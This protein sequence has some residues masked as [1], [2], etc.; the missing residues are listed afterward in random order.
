MFGTLLAILYHVCQD[1]LNRKVFDKMNNDLPPLI[2]SILSYEKLPPKTL[3]Q[4]RA[5]HKEAKAQRKKKI[6]KQRIMILLLSLS[7]AIT[8]ITW[9]MGII[10]A[11][12]LATK[13]ATF[14]ERSGIQA[15]ICFIVGGCITGLWSLLLL[16]GINKK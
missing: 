13:E 1:K 14:D 2:E 16:G 8:A 10:V 15:M 11:V 9:I 3:E 7:A 6:M 12:L 5:E 4:L